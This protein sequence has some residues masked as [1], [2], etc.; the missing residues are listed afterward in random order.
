MRT[1]KLDNAPSLMIFMNDLQMTT[2]SF[3]KSVQLMIFE[4]A[5]TDIPGVLRSVFSL[6]HFREP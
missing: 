3:S 1:L 6:E 4:C 2:E 5:I